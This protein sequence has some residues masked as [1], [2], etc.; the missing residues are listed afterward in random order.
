MLAAEFVSG[1][2]ELALSDAIG[3]DVLWQLEA[4]DQA[5]DGVS[6]LGRSGRRPS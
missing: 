2:L 3:R 5:L 6:A 1:A 4:C